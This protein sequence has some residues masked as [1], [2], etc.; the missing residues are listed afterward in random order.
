MTTVNLTVLQGAL[1]TVYNSLTWTGVAVINGTILWFE[2]SLTGGGQLS[3][4]GSF[5]LEGSSTKN[6]NADVR[7]HG[8]AHHSQGRVKFASKKIFQVLSNGTL[9]LYEN[10]LYGEAGS[11]IIIEGTLRIGL[12]NLFHS[13]APQLR[14][15]G[16]I[17]IELGAHFQLKSAVINGTVELRNGWLSTNGEVVFGSNANV[18]GFGGLS[19]TRSVAVDSGAKLDVPEI[20]NSGTLT[21]STSMTFKKLILSDGLISVRGSVNVTD[22]MFWIRGGI[23]SASRTSQWNIFGPVLLRPSSEKRLASV[24]FVSYSG[25]T[26]DVN[27]DSNNRYLR[28]Y[29]NGESRFIV[30]PGSYFD[31]ASVS[32]FQMDVP[33]VNKGFVAFTSENIILNEGITS[34]NECLIRSTSTLTLNGGLSVFDSTSRLTVYGTLQTNRYSRSAKVIINGALTVPINRISISGRGEL[35]LNT[36]GQIKSLTAS[37]CAITTF[38]KVKFEHLSVGSSATLTAVGKLSASFL[39]VQNYHSN[40]RLSDQTHDVDVLFFGGGSGCNLYRISGQPTLQV[41]DYFYVNDASVTSVQIALRNEIF[42]NGDNAKYFANGAK[43]VVPKA[44]QVTMTT[45]RKPRLSGRE[46]QIINNGT[47]LFRSLKRSLTS[48]TGHVVDIPLINNGNFSVEGNAWISVGSTSTGSIEVL[49]GSRLYL[50]GKHTWRGTI[51]SET[52]SAIIVLKSGDALDISGNQVVLISQLNIQSRASVNL[53]VSPL[54]LSL[55]VVSLERYSSLKCFQNCTVE[56]ELIWNS[57]SLLMA[58]ADTA[59]KLGRD[60]NLQAIQDTYYWYHRNIGSGLVI[61]QGTATFDTRQSLYVAGRFVVEGDVEIF[62]LPDISSEWRKSG[63]FINH[64]R[65]TVH[66]GATVRINLLFENHNELNVLGIVRL[67]NNAVG[68]SKGSISIPLASSAFISAVDKSFEIVNTSAIS[69][70]GTIHVEDDTLAIFAV[71]SKSRG[72]LGTVRVTGGTLRISATYFNLTRVEVLNRWSRLFLMTDQN[73]HIDNFVHR[74]ETSAVT[75]GKGLVTIGVLELS[76]SGRWG[77]TTIT[78]DSDV[79]V[80]TLAWGTRARLAGKRTITVADHLFVHGSSHVL[81]GVHLVVENSAV[82]GGSGDFD[83]HNGAIINIAAQANATIVTSRTFDGR[84]HRSSRSSGNKILIDGKLRCGRE[85]AVIALNVD[86]TNNG[87]LSLEKGTLKL[88][89]T[90][91]HSGTFDAAPST[92]VELRGTTTFLP[93]SNVSLAA[94]SVL[95]TST[96]NFNTATPKPTFSSLTVSSGT[97]SVNTRKGLLIRTEI[98]MTSGTIQLR[99]RLRATRLYMKRSNAIQISDDGFVDVDELHWLSGTIKGRGG[100]SPWFIVRRLAQLTSTSSRTIEAGAIVFKQRAAL[101]ENFNKLTLLRA[102]LVND[103]TFI[104]DSAGATVYSTSGKFVNNG[105]LVVDVGSGKASLYPDFYNNDGWITVKSGQLQLLHRSSHDNGGLELEPETSIQF[106]GSDHNFDNSASLLFDVDTTVYV[107]SGRLSIYANS[108]N[109][110]FSK[111]VV[112]GGNVLVHKAVALHPFPFLRVSG[113]T[114]RFNVSTRIRKVILSGGT[115]V[116]PQRFQIDE[117]LMSSTSTIKGGRPKERALLTVG[118]FL[119]RRG[120]IDAETTTP[121]RYFFVNVTDALT[122]ASLRSACVVRRTDLISHTQ[123]VVS[124]SSSSGLHLEQDAR[125]I[126]SHHGT[127]TLQMGRIGGTATLLNYGRL[128]VET[129]GSLEQFTLDARLVNTGGQVSVNVGQL[130]LN[131]GGL[132]NGT[133]DRVYIAEETRLLVGGNTFQ[134]LP[135]IIVGQGSVEIVSG[136]VFQMTSSS[137]LFLPLTVSTG[138][139]IVVAR[140]VVGATFDATVT[141]N[142]GMMQVDG[143]ANVTSDLSL[144]SGSMTGSGI[145]IIA[146]TGRMTTEFN[147][148]S[149]SFNIANQVQN[150]G[151]FLLKESV[152]VSSNG[153]L[154]NE[155]TGRVTI[156]G[157]GQIFGSGIVENLGLMTCRLP[158]NATCKLATQ[159]R[160]YK[161]LQIESGQMELSRSPW[162]VDGSTL[163]GPGRLGSVV[164]LRVGGHVNVNWTVTSN[165]AIDGPLFST[166]T[167][168][169]TAGVLSSLSSGSCTAYSPQSSRVLTPRDCKEDFFVNEGS[170]VIDGSGAKQINSDLTLINR[171]V[172]EWK[173]GVVTVAGSL[174]IDSNSMMTA[175]ADFGTALRLSGNGHVINKGLLSI[176]NST[177]LI[178]ANLQNTG[179]ISLNDA[180]LTVSRTMTNRGVVTGF[181]AISSI[182]V[183]AGTVQPFGARRIALGSDFSQS[184]EGILTVTVIESDGQFVSSLL[185]CTQAKTVLLAGTVNVVWNATNTLLPGEEGPPILTFGSGV[186]AGTIDAVTVKG[187]GGM[188]L[189]L[190]YKSTSVVLKRN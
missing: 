38:Q 129:S 180:T 159:F 187:G 14:H 43:I 54:L 23:S 3:I 80:A 92:I 141:M 49:N 149:Q 17:I 97:F 99:S 163:N 190:A 44:A 171:G 61:V 114:V 25:S 176:V 125:F 19:L 35:I 24:E 154:R 87:L 174:L 150:Y 158:E 90:N 95:S 124:S 64:G 28:I 62:D 128:I 69:G 76:S 109:V 107:T 127:T 144:V 73:S 136:G 82:F 13:T 65:V 178:S 11:Q 119:F 106:G 116:V 94:S 83:L 21:L 36:T 161:V 52:N 9:S 155:K 151:D 102:T 166:K 105:T 20:R 183:N 81:D 130:R 164:N 115:V 5:V 8:Q 173:A 101:S 16:L 110:T 121:G 71:L 132:C 111:V 56:K 167:C 50:S 138:G 34:S 12:R 39:H 37:S 113:G 169:W 172:V 160:N 85:F 6:L 184:S 143:L 74:T 32:Q 26:I 175:V 140:N 148:I 2:S 10:N 108:S 30:A 146:E 55:G 118:L 189:A 123:T 134:C 77:T 103:G 131:R 186:A 48:S 91:V 104:L 59:I 79:R 60:S 18:S 45:V 142:G 135:Q 29:R 120:T 117:L 67:H 165:V 89:G 40:I 88:L 181:G 177:M 96:V 93:T 22:L 70:K 185:D 84:S 63:A 58:N 47:L 15:T 179:T 86:F 188:V 170:L 122:V 72:F 51:R 27:V 1:L 78:G 68:W 41:N 157:E 66:H 168:T 53:N 75:S 145:V 100:A 33:L 147:S 182:F 126:N 31:V 42:L 112:S 4:Y 46:G 156:A 98:R 137:P 133:G 7:L 139:R 152:D 153:R 162:L 57:G